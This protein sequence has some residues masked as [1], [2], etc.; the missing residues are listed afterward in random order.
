MLAG[1][2]RGRRRAGH[3]RAR[4]ARSGG[5]GRAAARR[6]WAARSRSAS[7]AACTCST[8]ASSTCAW[9]RPR[10]PLPRRRATSTSAR[11]PPDAL[12]EFPR[13][14]ARAD[15]VLLTR[16]SGG[17]RR[18]PRWRALGA[19][20]LF[21]VRRRVLGFFD[22]AGTRAAGAAPGRSWSPA[23]RARSASRRTCAAR[24]ARLGG[25]GAASA[26]ITASRAGEWLG[27]LR[28][29]RAAGRRRGGHDGQG[30][31]AAAA[32]T[33]PS[34][35]CWCCASQAVRRGRAALPRAGCWRRR[36]ASR[37][38]TA[39]ALRAR[40]ARGRADDGL[41]ARLPRRA[42]LALGRGLGRLWGDLDRRHVAIAADN[43]RRAFPH[44]DEARVL[45]TARDVYAHLGAM[46]L[47]VL[48]MSRRTREEIL[49]LV[50]VEGRRA[51]RGR[52]GRGTRR[53]V[54]DRP[55]RKLGA[56]RGWP[57]AG[58]SSPSAV[59]ARP[60]DN[61]FLDRRL[62]AARSVSRQRGDLQGAGARAA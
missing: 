6:A 60:L 2:A 36:G 39:A 41:V 40:G 30:R 57:T 32:R 61:P 34:R 35:R 5:G 23:S 4:A 48:W 11:C 37:V 15:L 27:L 33:R 53:A 9:P 29:A 25:P 47:D 62:C 22:L 19:E 31:G 59:V 43:L 56:E 52:D 49:S 12:R 44:W 17:V 55:L 18:S 28:A 42:A 3:A 14:A 10:P 24:V 1:A 13:R 51:R 8:T 21:R 20:R 45:R 50:E 46:L 26:T 38:T 16:A 7:A 58:C 54:R